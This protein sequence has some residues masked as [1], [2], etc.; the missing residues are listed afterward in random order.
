[1]NTTDKQRAS[2]T[3]RKAKGPGAITY[4]LAVVGRL[5]RVTTPK[6]ARSEQS[7]Q[8]V[9]GALESL[10]KTKSFSEISVPEIAA[11]AERGTASLYGRFKD[12]GSMLA[13]LHESLHERLANDIA[14]EFDP[15]RW[16]GKDLDALIDHFCVRNVN[17]Y[18]EH[19]NLLTAALIS[20]DRE[21]YERGALTIGHVSSHFMEALRVVHGSKFVSSDEPRMD[22]CVRGVFALLQQRLLFDA[23][24][25]GKHAKHSDRGFIEELS[26]LLRISM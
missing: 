24:S 2:T 3:G 8:R 7:V 17:F 21:I 18:K 23:V 11:Q 5:D 19:K 6:Q 10:L 16:N 22:L 12:K 15:L 14:H 25:I 13:A 1:M 26:T 4:D 20:G 9:L